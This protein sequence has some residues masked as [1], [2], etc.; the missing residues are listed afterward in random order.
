MTVMND[1][2]QAGGVLRDNTIE[3]MMNRRLYNANG[4]GTFQP[5][6]ETQYAFYDADTNT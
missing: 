4:D 1:R 6:N 2:C 3:L 5:L